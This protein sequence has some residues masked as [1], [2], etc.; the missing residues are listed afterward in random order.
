MSCI[1]CHLVST[2]VSH[3]NIKYQVA[4]ILR[5]VQVLQHFFLQNNITEVN[6]TVRDCYPGYYMAGKE[7]VINRT[8][9]ILRP[10]RFNHYLYIKVDFIVYIQAS[11]YA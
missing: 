4:L 9:P 11:L 6:V 1:A 3:A 8:S 10:D 7:C 2:V 5:R